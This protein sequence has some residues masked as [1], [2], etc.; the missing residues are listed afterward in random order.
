MSSLPKY[1]E[2]LIVS[3]PQPAVIDEKRDLVEIHRVEN[4]AFQQQN[5]MGMGMPMSMPAP[6]GMSF[7]PQP[8]FD[9]NALA[10]GAPGYSG[11]YPNAPADMNYQVPPQAGVQNPEFYDPNTTAQNQPNVQNYYPPHSGY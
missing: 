8:M 1:S 2:F 3:A 11:Y 4:P 10:Q 7:P 9:P 6:I 5:M